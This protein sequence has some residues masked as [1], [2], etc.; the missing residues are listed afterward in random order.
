ML[1]KIAKF[2]PV[3]DRRSLRLASKDL[4]DMPELTG[5]GEEAF[6]ET[7]LAKLGDLSSLKTI[8]DRAF[9]GTPL[10]Q[11]GDLSSLKPISRTGSECDTEGPGECTCAPTS[12]RHT[13]A[14]LSPDHLP[15]TATH[16]EVIFCAQCAYAPE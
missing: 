16:V 7:Q 11:L 1:S 6:E 12:S 5:I 2:L 10:A 14:V 15:S 8:G 4:G 13:C 9:Y 3:A